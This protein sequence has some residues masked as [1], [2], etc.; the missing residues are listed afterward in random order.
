[1]G[2]LRRPQRA[3]DGAG[4]TGV[5]PCGGIAVDLNA[6]RNPFGA[7]SVQDPRLVAVMARHG[8]GFGGRWPVP[9]PMHFE[10]RGV[11]RNGAP[12]GGG[13]PSRVPPSG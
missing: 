13:A 12:T 8:F 2:R 7:R 9:D 11:A 3:L 4:W 5:A 10:Y 1:S 6:A